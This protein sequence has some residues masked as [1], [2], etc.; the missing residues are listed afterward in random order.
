MDRTAWIAVILCSLGILYFATRP[1][2]Q[3]PNPGVGPDG[4]P[5]VIP[6]EKPVPGPG[7]APADGTPAPEPGPQDPPPVAVA[8]KTLEIET[9]KVVFTFST[10]GGGVS[11]ARLKEHQALT[12]ED[13][14][15]NGGFETQDGSAQPPIGALSRGSNLPEPL[16][17]SM[18]QPDPRTVVF[19]GVT[20]SKIEITKTYRLTDGVDTGDP[21]LLEL[22]VDFKN[23]SG[24]EQTLSDYSLYAGVLT[25]LHK[26]EQFFY[27]LYNWCNDGDVGYKDVNWFN[28]GKFI[29]QFRSPSE[30]LTDTMEDLQWGGP[31]NQ[32]F[33]SLVIPDQRGPGSIWA[34]RTEVTI[35][36]IEE[37][38]GSVKKYYA[39]QG[40]VS[41]PPMKLAADGIASFGY[42]LYT[43]PRELQ[44]LEKIGHDL[45]GV[46][47]YD[48]MPIFGGMMGIIPVV[49]SFLLKLM[50]KLGA[51]VG[52]WGV[53]ILIITFL[54]RVLIWPLHAKSTKT[55][56]RMAKLSP[57][58]TDL[59]E[60]YS[61]DPQKMQTET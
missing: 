58:I 56:K 44:R 54:I 8:E 60:K 29:V 12:G 11:R 57:M 50:I 36:G 46:M 59:R 25:H 6:E 43:G 51:M 22:D 52:N 26:D 15:I 39:I 27:V 47:H 32:F 7:E 18:T 5:V 23:V 48:T 21:Y 20:P 37:A 31:N 19:R 53:A 42:Q 2:P 30:L 10:R 16:D 13:I 1:V 14:I 24:I 38:E 9:D 33:T 41:V 3:M 28:G 45:K 40:G 35:P 4:N 49:S 55:M 17:Y 34:R 61:D